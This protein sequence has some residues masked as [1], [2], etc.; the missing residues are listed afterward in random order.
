MLVQNPWSVY[1]SFRSSRGPLFTWE[2]VKSR[3]GLAA[4][5]KVIASNAVKE[6]VLDLVA[7]FER[8]TGHKVTM[9]WASTEASMRQSFQRACTPQRPRWMP[10]KP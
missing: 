10:P 2:D 5:L 7:E 3:L 6:A 4:E 1:R 8:S 9:I